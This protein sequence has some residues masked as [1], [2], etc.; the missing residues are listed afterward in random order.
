MR[1]IPI[2]PFL[3]GLVSLLTL[4]A[5][6]MQEVYLTAVIKPFLCTLGGLMALL[7][8]MRLVFRDW[9]RAALGTTFIAVIFFSYGHV[10][11]LL[12]SIPNIGL[13]VGR[14]R[15]LLV[16]MAGLLVAGL[17]WIW[18]KFRSSK[19]ITLLL[20]LTGLVLLVFPLY[21][22]S[23]FYIQQG[24][25]KNAS[26]A[27]SQTPS[28]LSVE[29]GKPAPDVYYIILDSYTR[30]DALL[31][32]FGY[33]NAPFE[34][35]LEELGFYI[36][37]CSQSNYSY[38][39]LSLVSSLNMDYLGGIQEELK[40]Q[41]VSP[42]AWL[43][44]LKKSAVRGQLEGIGYKTIA[45]QTGFPWTELTDADIFLDM[46]ADIMDLKQ[47]SPF[48]VMYIKSTGLLAI[49]DRQKQVTR[50]KISDVNYP[51][52]SFIAQ[53]RFILDQLPKIA[54]MPE[55]KFVFAH[56]LIPHVP[57]IFAAD[58]SI[59]LDPGFYDGDDTA[60]RNEEY[61]TRGYTGEI[62]F[63][64]REIL[65][66]VRQILADSKT[67]PVIIIQAD[68]GL[69]DQNRTMIFNAYYLPGE[70]KNELYTTITPVNT[71]RLVFDEYFGANYP[72]LADDSFLRSNY[73]DPVPDPNPACQTP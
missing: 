6:N 67:P 64:N 35:E 68:H 58:G 60:P 31:G 27:L 30:S 11:E 49:T 26:E 22:I 4:L 36:A 38:T 70:G 20:N 59:N 33:D 44:M 56:I 7:A 53:Q 10:Y 46:S 23:S 1:R 34:N 24:S 63:I 66:V 25:E 3:F 73:T 69:R 17:W 12:Q 37:R 47:L 29:A 72:L 51:F 57:Y 61:R 15:Y 39:S 19:E 40:A 9:S 62:Q 65:Q 18:K 13:Q 48:D 52:S 21:Q 50:S 71:F 16:V 43:G 28:R 5:H 14:H 45:F 32:D 54:S 2:Y 8:L 42:N 41:G 55:K